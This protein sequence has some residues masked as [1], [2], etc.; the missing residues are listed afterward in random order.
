MLVRTFKLLGNFQCPFSW[1]VISRRVA[2][3][4]AISGASVCICLWLMLLLDCDSLGQRSS[5]V[6][7][8]CCLPQKMHC[9]FVNT[10]S[11]ISIDFLISLYCNLFT[12]YS[13]KHLSQFIT[14][15]WR[16][17]LHCTVGIMLALIW[18]LLRLVF[19]VL[20]FSKEIQQHTKTL[21]C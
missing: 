15:F 9:S 5:F 17:M 11:V 2:R 10:T 16:N 1:L 8:E 20:E 14:N 12:I 3:C 18:F 19:V 21:W 7:H 4:L 13:T 6:S